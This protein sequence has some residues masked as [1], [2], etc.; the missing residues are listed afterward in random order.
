M[1]KDNEMREH[2]YHFWLALTVVSVML[3]WL[4]IDVANAETIATPTVCCVNVHDLPDAPSHH[5]ATRASV[6]AWVTDAGAKAFDAW[7]TD[8]T[9]SEG[10]RERDPIAKPFVGSR[11]GR[12]AYFG[13]S[14]G[15]DIGGSY[16]LHR[17][18]H[19]KL[20][21]ILPWAGAL[22][23]FGYG[24]YTASQYHPPRPTRVII[25]YSDRGITLH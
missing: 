13:A 1:R 7:G 25:G 18:G 8:R 14:L 12:I 6:S 21:R 22:M 24:A 2:D 19:H 23:S 11:G 16:L 4:L 5:F 9:L 15:L 20:E 10:G 17:T 3:F